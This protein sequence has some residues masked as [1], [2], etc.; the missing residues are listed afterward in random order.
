[1]AHP[2][3]RKWCGFKPALTDFFGFCCFA[4]FFDGFA[5]PHSIRRNVAQRNTSSDLWKFKLH[6]YRLIGSASV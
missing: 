1:M 5:M 3:R 4:F 2:D 6:H